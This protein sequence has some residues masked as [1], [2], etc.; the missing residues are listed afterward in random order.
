MI[1]VK[2]STERVIDRIKEGTQDSTDRLRSCKECEVRS[3]VVDVEEM[4]EVQK[5]REKM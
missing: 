2:N 3:E 5:C 1:E 4:K